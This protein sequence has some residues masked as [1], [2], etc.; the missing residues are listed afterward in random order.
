MQLHSTYLV[1]SPPT[2]VSLCE[3][4]GQSELELIQTRMTQKPML[5]AEVGKS[6]WFPHTENWGWVDFL[7][8]RCSGDL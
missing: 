3:D 6:A 2:V 8:G 4:N 1:I 7:S 5:W